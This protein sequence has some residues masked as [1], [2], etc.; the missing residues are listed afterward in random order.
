MK[1]E[2]PVLKDLV[3]RVDLDVNFVPLNGEMLRLRYGN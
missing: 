1:K 3:G 2:E